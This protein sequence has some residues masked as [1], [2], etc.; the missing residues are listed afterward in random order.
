MVP[1]PY[2]FRGRVGGGYGKLAIWMPFYIFK[3]WRDTGALELVRTLT[4]SPL[5]EADTYRR[6]EAQLR[7]LRRAADPA[8]G[9]YVHLV[10]GEDEADAG[11]KLQAQLGA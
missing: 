3:V 4:P 9:Y 11:A 1:D 2:W 8:D 5:N 7:E 10:Y 6:A